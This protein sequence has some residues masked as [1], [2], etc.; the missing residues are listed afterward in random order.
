MMPRALALAGLAG[1]LEDLSQ[2]LR[3]QGLQCD[4]ETFGLEQYSL[5]QIQSV[6][7]YRIVQELTHNVIKHAQASHLLLQLILKDNT[8]TIIAEDDGQGFDVQAA[9]QQKGL[10][11][12]SIESRVQYLQGH[13]E[14][15]S[16]P[17]EGTTVSISLA[18]PCLY[19]F[20]YFFKIQISPEDFGLAIGELL[21]PSHAHA[22]FRPFSGQCEPATPKAPFILSKTTT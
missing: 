11:L 9:L 19:E 4:L 12:S 18:F 13:I 16:V 20:R 8:L 7:V 2:D 22:Q 5:P 17:G 21:L 10:G 1:A 15:D 14:W 3:Q 6:M